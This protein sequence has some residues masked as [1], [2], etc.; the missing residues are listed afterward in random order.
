MNQWL[1]TTKYY[2]QLVYLCHCFCLF[3]ASTYRRVL[4]VDYIARYCDIC[5]S[6]VLV[7]THMNLNTAEILCTCASLVLWIAIKFHTTF[8][9]RTY[10]ILHTL[11][12]AVMRKEVLISVEIT[13]DKKATLCEESG[14]IIAITLAILSIDKISPVEEWLYALVFFYLSILFLQS[15]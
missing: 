13:G 3:Y 7:R 1:I 9:I 4:S 10:A 6:T 2:I 5:F 8:C 12:Y 11:C 14:C 15:L